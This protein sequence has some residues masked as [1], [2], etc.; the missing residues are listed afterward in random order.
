V[1]QQVL[2]QPELPETSEKMVGAPNL[3]PSDAVICVE[4]A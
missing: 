3:R 4:E 1:Y 2:P